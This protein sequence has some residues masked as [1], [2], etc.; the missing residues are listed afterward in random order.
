[1]RDIT[2]A[3]IIWILVSLVS[4]FLVGIIMKIYGGPE[5]LAKDGTSIITREHDG[6]KWIVG[7]IWDNSISIIHHPDC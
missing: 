3:I 1:M 2:E 7:T 6:H 4:A 5:E